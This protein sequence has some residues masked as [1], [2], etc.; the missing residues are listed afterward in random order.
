[1][2]GVSGGPRLPTQAQQQRDAGLRRVRT[3]TWTAAFGAA[4]L[5]AVAATIAAN[6]IPGHTANAAAASG[7]AAG[8][9][10]SQTPQPIPTDGVQAPQPGGGPPV[11][12][13]GGS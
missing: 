3:I 6:T 5:T 2:A 13:T 12:V 11:V 1:M 10:G 9:S 8:D 4:A 7:S